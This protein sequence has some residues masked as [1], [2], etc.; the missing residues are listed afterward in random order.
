MATAILGAARPSVQPQFC[1]VNHCAAMFGLSVQTI[2][3]YADNPAN[4]VEVR[5]SPGGHRYVNLAQI[6]EVFGFTVESEPDPESRAS[7]EEV[8]Q[9][10]VCVLY[11][12]V[13]TRSQC[14]DKNLERQAGRLRAY[15]EANH[16]DELATCLQVSEQAS[17]INSERRGL[18]KIIDLA[19]A[20]RLGTLFIEHEE[21]LSRGSYALI[22]RLLAKCGVEIVVTRTGERESTAKDAES[23]IFADAMSMIYVGQSRLYGKRA[24][25]GKRFIASAALRDRIA[26]LYAQGLSGGKIFGVI[27]R[28]GHVCQSTGKPATIK[29]VWG[30]IKQIERAAPSKRVPES[31]RRFVKEACTVSPS[32][33]ALNS[34]VWEAFRQFCET[35]ALPAVSRNKLPA[36]I[37]ATVPSVRTKRASNRA[38]GFEV[39]GLAPKP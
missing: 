26:G 14:L 13:S 32:Q 6:A 19:L 11:S 10:K 7:A 36:F 4:G 39:H 27:A 35:H 24:S 28:E 20:G 23:E 25:I 5:R 12:R 31:V 15:V 21:R 34:Q 3:N 30:V 37:R 17:G 22:A 1:R 16:P 29:T 2:R 33:M 18:T 8:R 9:G 38:N